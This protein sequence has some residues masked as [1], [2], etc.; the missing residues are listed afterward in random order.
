MI[1]NEAAHETL[2]LESSSQQSSCLKHG[3]F[4]CY[5]TLFYKYASEELDYVF[6][7][8]GDIISVRQPGYT[9]QR[10]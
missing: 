1:V 6:I 7:D 2:G 3:F 9:G 8:L 5:I 4:N 10:I